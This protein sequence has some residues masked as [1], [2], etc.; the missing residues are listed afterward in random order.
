VGRPDRRAR[1]RRA[2]PREQVPAPRD[3]QNV[4]LTDHMNDAVNSLRIVL[5]A[6]ESARTG[7]TIELGG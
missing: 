2:L 1:P 6:D 3:P 4:D 5:A 7:K